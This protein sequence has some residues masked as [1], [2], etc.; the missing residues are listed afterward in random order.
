MSMNI[1]TK[2]ILL[3]AAT[4]S[5]QASA[6][7]IVIN[8]GVGFDDLTAPKAGQKGN[9]PGNNL[10]EL[11]LN[12]FQEA[13]NVWGAIL[14]STVTITVN[15]K[16]E[17]FGD[18]ECTGPFAQLGHAGP[19]STREDFGSGDPNIAYAVALA[20]SLSG[21]N[22]NGGTAEID[23][24][25]NARV[26]LDPECLGGGGFYYGLDDNAPV[27]TSA[28]FATVLHEMGHG[29]GFLSYVNSNGS[30]LNGTMDPYSRLLKDLETGKSWPNMSNA[31]RSASLLNEPNLVWTGAKVTAD[32]ALHL[33][34]APELRIN[35]PAPAG[36]F[37]AA[38]GQQSTA[39]P[40]GGLTAAVFDGNSVDDLDADADPADGCSQID[41]GGTF[42]GKIVLFDKTDSCSA[43]IQVFFSQFEGAVGVIIADTTG[44]GLPDV[45][46]GIGNPLT[47]PYI[48]VNK[49][50]ADQLRSNIGSANASI[51][52]SASKLV[53]ENQGMLK[54]YAPLA[55]SSGSSVSHWSKTASPDLLMEPSQGNLT[56]QN[57]DLTAAAFQDIGWSVNIPGGV[58]EVIYRDGF[59]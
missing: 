40:G 19:T 59:E 35:A 49:S 12:L 58:V 46:G 54:M 50:E 43:A 37:E 29:L 27:D 7:T 39:I 32:R 6:A 5:F 31:E 55:Y 33:D 13:A 24:A 30:W 41:F 11:R 14:N 57:V 25:F 15:A 26:D 17:N 44:G 53:G 42:A 45:S 56:Y 10:G 51:Q 21:T 48:G 47:I 1:Q 22:Q 34:P 18:T 36:T 9:N 16:F 3:C 20:E 23:A 4:F 2:I 28:L 52:N 38:L 8:P